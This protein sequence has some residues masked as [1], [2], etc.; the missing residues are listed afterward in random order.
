MP[1]RAVYTLLFIKSDLI[2]RA[3]F[4]P[5]PKYA[6]MGFWQQPQTSRARLSY[7]VEAALKS[8]GNKCAR[9]V[10]VIGEEFWTQTLSMPASAMQGL[11]REQVAKA[12]G[13][14]VEAL[15]GISGSDSA[16]GYCA[17]APSDESEHLWITQVPLGAREQIQSAVEAAGAELAGILHPGGLPGPI[18]HEA[19]D[20]ASWRRIE[21]WK[22]AT[23]CIVGQDHQPPRVTVINGERQPNWRAGVA[24]WIA[25]HPATHS[26]WLDSSDQTIPGAS[27]ALSGWA[28]LPA[29]TGQPLQDWLRQWA[30]AL[31]EGNRPAPLIEPRRDTGAGARHVVAAAVIALLCLGA[32]IFRA[33]WLANQQD[34]LLHQIEDAQAPK[35]ELTTLQKKSDGLRNELAQVKAERARHP[36]MQVHVAPDMELQRQRIVAL[37]SALQDHSNPDVVVDHIAPGADGSVLIEGKCFPASAVDR[38]TGALASSLPPVGWEVSP[39][40][41]KPIEG[42]P[43]GSACQFSLKASPSSAGPVD[44]RE[45]APDS[46]VA[47]GAG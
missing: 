9:S 31:N 36:V 5:A 19:A 4:G 1:K 6:P 13:F 23:L 11:S 24:R 17:A 42:L 8:G 20:S 30:I 2:A 7:S 10:W 18:K 32:C 33:S 15:T 26:E 35:R 16:I 28:A 46:T 34:R 43:P 25:A 38:L 45:Q 12:V 41:K 47:G 14:D 39:A 40:E 21:S 29:L 27:E 22:A 3:D 44:H 37:L